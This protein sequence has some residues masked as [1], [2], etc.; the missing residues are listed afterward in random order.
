MISLFNPLRTKD[1]IFLQSVYI[2]QL[3]A[4]VDVNITR[5]A[6]AEAKAK[7][8][9]A[10]ETATLQDNTPALSLIKNPKRSPGV[11]TLQ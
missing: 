4:S 11:D 10:P 8:L 5:R 7:V 2:A 9:L 6:A 1:M 3:I